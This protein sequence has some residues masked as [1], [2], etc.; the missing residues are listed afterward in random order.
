[1]GKPCWSEI[2]DGGCFGIAHAPV[3]L[4][5]SLC[6]KL[7]SGGVAFKSAIGAKVCYKI[8]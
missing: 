2:S 8:R 7:D 1:M 6:I 4:V 5:N 3:S